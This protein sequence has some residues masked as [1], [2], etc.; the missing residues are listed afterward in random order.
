[1]YFRVGMFPTSRKSDFDVLRRYPAAHPL[2]QRVNIWPL[3]PQIIFTTLKKSIAVNY[4]SDNKKFTRPDM[5]G[6]VQIEVSANLC[7]LPVG[8]E[9][10]ESRLG[11]QNRALRREN[12]SEPA[13][14]LE[15][16]PLSG[17]EWAPGWQDMALELLDK[18]R[19]NAEGRTAPLWWL[20]WKG[21]CKPKMLL[22]VLS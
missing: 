6:H 13:L 20:I 21:L 19:T 5:S 12:H 2:T 15:S 7:T 10:L 18:Q 22:A 4:A 1:M 16:L 9:P 3:L 14:G 8:K 11:S 17:F